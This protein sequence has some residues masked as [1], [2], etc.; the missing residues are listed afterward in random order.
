MTV[1][2]EF[3]LSSTEISNRQFL[4]IAYLFTMYTEVIFQHRRSTRA[5]SSGKKIPTASIIAES[6]GPLSAIILTVGRSFIHVCYY[7]LT[8]IQPYACIHVHVKKKFQTAV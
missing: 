3:L 1:R 6:P 4:I 5:V 2:N 7:S 8:E